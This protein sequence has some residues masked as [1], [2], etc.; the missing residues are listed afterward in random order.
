MNGNTR[1]S[2]NTEPLSFVDGPT[3]CHLESRSCSD[4]DSPCGRKW[5][6]SRVDVTEIV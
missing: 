5:S 3:T 4:K 6:L 1:Q 2:F